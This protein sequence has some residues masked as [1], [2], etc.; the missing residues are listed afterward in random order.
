MV[1]IHA[2]AV[3]E[4]IFT[5]WLER[6]EILPPVGVSKDDLSGLGYSWGVQSLPWF[7]LT[8]KNHVV[9][10]EG[11]SLAELDEKITMLNKK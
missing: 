11:F 8:D 3:E 2:G 10:A 6:N 1:F 9:I 5:S 4:K 7:T